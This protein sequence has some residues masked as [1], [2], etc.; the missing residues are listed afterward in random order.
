MLLSVQSSPTQC[1]SSQKLVVGF[2]SVNLS[3][4]DI[5]GSFYS[6]KCCPKVYKSLKIYKI[7]FNNNN[8]ESLEALS[9]FYFVSHSY[10]NFEIILVR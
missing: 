5:K 2:L 6:H 7:L 3:Y 10:P 9:T 1:I 4:I 8:N